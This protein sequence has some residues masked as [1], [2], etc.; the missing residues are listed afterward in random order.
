MSE[1][2]SFL[3][4]YVCERLQSMMDVQFV[5][6]LG[7][8]TR[9]ITK[10]GEVRCVMNV[11][12]KL[13]AYGGG[14]GGAVFALADQ[15]FALA[16]NMGKEKQ[17]AMVASINYIKPGTGVLEAVARRTSETKKT[18]LYEVKVFDDGKLVAVFQ[19]TGYKIGE[20]RPTASR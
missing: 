4:K 10:D 18:S 17:V 2:E 9:S 12:D 16:S 5:V 7:I 8:E 13:N 19:G 1:W 11:S 3:P 20:K 14:H 6:D 15:A